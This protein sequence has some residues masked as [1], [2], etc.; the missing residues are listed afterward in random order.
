[1]SLDS[2]IGSTVAEEED[3]LALE[4]GHTPQS[5]VVSDCLTQQV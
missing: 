2:V 1:M 4:A 5:F 3:K